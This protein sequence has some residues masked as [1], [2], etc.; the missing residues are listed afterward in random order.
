MGLSYS[1]K[2]ELVRCYCFDSFMYVI[3]WFMIEYIVIFDKFNFYYKNIG[4]FAWVNGDF[5]K[6]GWFIMLFL[7]IWVD[8]FFV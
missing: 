2:W 8:I 7:V 4:F 6:F 1:L 3:I 5:F